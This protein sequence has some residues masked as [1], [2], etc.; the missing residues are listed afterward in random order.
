MTTET[1]KLLDGVVTEA[2]KG[3]IADVEKALGT[4]MP[5]VVKEAL[6]TT[7]KCGYVVGLKS[8]VEHFTE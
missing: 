3:H 8:A 7:F 5:D 6:F 1:R 2:F 4:D